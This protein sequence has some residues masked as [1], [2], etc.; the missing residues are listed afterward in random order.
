MSKA[1]DIS[2]A[3]SRIA[4]GLL[5]ALSEDLQLIEMTYNHTGNQKKD[6]I[7]LGDIDIRSG[8]PFL[9]ILKYRDHQ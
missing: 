4:I 5:N 9:N 6:H 2:T 3:T 1:L 8:R 7:S